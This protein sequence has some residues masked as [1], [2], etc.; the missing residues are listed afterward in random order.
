ML[1][2][3]ADTI[4]CSWDFCDLIVAC[5][6][7]DTKDDPSH[8][9]TRYLEIIDVYKHHYY[10][11][12]FVQQQQHTPSYSNATPSLLSPL[13]FS[14]YP[15][16]RNNNSF[17]SKNNN[18]NNNNDTGDT[19]LDNTNNKA[20]TNSHTVNNNNNS[21]PAKK[22]KTSYGTGIGIIC[23][24]YLIISS[25]LSHL[26]ILLFAEDIISTFISSNGQGVT[27]EQTLLH[28]QSI[29]PTQTKQQVD[30]VLSKVMH[31][32]IFHHLICL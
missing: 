27:A 5:F 22:Q 30:T 20:N 4:Y 25:L 18:K 9:I 17:I 16:I 21:A 23:V 28:T 12:K 29:Q 6:S 10:K 2:V 24:T 14:S 13:R 1:W 11:N 31:L 26:S 15:T 8:E 3:C 19:I 32:S 7:I